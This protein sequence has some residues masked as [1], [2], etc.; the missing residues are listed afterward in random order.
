MLML[1]RA[2]LRLAGD[3]RGPLVRCTAVG[4]TLFA[5]RV[6]QA[7]LVGLVLGAVLDGGDAPALMVAATALV[8][9]VLLRAGL[10]WARD[11]VSQSSA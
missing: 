10:V 3:L 8:G 4:W 6:L 7:V 9:V 5:V 11:L 2:L 1:H